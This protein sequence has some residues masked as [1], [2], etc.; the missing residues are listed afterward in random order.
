IETRRQQRQALA[1]QLEVRFRKFAAGKIP[2]DFLQSIVQQWTTA[3]SAE[4]RAVADYNTAI[5]G[6][7]FGKGTLMEYDNVHILD[8]SAMIGEPVRA[9]DHE[10]LR[11]RALTR[12]VQSRV[13]AAGPAGL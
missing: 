9:V 8:G 3:L 13:V 10:R 7:H 1:E 5:A 11:T 4:Y 6:F 2:V 12:R